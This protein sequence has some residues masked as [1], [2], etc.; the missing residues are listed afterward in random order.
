MI[1]HP[2]HNLK[3]LKIVQ[4]R[5]HPPSENALLNG[6]VS[7]YLSPHSSEISLIMAR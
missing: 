1:F 3:R 5:S 7:A 2:F 6:M 4:S